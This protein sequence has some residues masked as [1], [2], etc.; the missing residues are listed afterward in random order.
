MTQLWSLG[1][2]S[3][4]EV[5]NNLSLDQVIEKALLLLESGLNE[6]LLMVWTQGWPNWMN[7]NEVPEISEELKL[8]RK[9]A[10]SEP[11]PLPPTS[12]P[13][14]MKPKEVE[15]I[16]LKKEKNNTHA[17]SPKVSKE[18]I[19]PIN[20]STGE[21]FTQKRKHHRIFSR[22]RCLIR[23][24]TIT[25]RTFTKDI[26]LGGVSLEDEIP[27]DLIGQECSIY[28][29]SN[30]IKKNLKFKIALTER[31]VAKYFSFQD[32]PPDFLDELS[33]WLNDFEKNSKAS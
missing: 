22:L 25:F 20:R 9:P 16:S 11:P 27:Q 23:T 1:N 10:L 19:Q 18:N 21:N 15:N 4:N 32:A 3:T 33:T 24:N 30:K 28:I 7:I 5:N 17:V 2:H 13:P 14:L 8:K 6:K 31:S 26:S 12:V 29:A